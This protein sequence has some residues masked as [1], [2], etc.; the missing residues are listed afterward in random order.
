[1]SEIEILL[2]SAYRQSRWKNGQGTTYDI[3]SAPDGAGWDGLIWRLSLADIERDSAFSEFPGFDRTF[4]AIAGG[5]LTLEPEGHASIAVE[6]LHEPVSFPGEWRMT[7]RLHAGPTRDFNVFSARGRAKHGLRIVKATESA[8]VRDLAF[9][10]VLGGD[11]R[12]Q[13]QSVP[14]G[15]TCRAKAGPLDIVCGVGGTAILVDIVVEKAT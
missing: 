4:V 7:C 3:A 6:R 11:V 1:M 13:G 12:C 10:Y 15:A 9:L 5:G 8:R 14:I 2:P